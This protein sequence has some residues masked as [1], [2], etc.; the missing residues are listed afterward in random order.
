M[1]IHPLSVSAER[2]TDRPFPRLSPRAV[3]ELRTS[4]SLPP[5]DVWCI[6]LVAHDAQGGSTSTQEE[7]VAVEVASKMGSTGIREWLARKREVESAAM[8]A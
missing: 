6:S 5:L 3:N 1:R 8:Q 7:K 4:R 2:S